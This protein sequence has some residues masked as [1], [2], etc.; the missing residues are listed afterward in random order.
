MEPLLCH[1][2]LNTNTFCFFIT[3]SVSKFSLYVNSDKK[4]LIEVE[5]RLKD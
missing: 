4:T 5:S 1:D 3:V 2:G